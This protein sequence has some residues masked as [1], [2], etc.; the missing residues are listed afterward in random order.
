MER[1]YKVYN[2]R[3]YR[4]I[5]QVQKYLSEEE[6]HVIDVVGNVLPFKVNNYVTDNLIDWTNIPD[7]PIFQLTFPQFGMLT[8][9]D[10]NKVDGLL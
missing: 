5:P 3:N 10:F 2:L 8:T 1:K 4:E 7:D 6:K 9:E